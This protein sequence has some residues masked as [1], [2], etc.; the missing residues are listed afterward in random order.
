MRRRQGY[1]SKWDLTDALRPREYKGGGGGSV[2]GIFMTWK[3]GGLLDCCIRL[4]VT[5]PEHGSEI[6]IA[7]AERDVGYVKPLWHLLW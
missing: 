1:T 6:G 2:V 4:K 3:K 7:E 5:Y